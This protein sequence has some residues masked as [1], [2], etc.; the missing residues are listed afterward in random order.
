ME[1][2]T[3]FIAILFLIT[4]IF[5]LQIGEWKGRSLERY[6]YVMARE[7]RDFWYAAYCALSEDTGYAIDPLTGRKVKNEDS[8]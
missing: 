4:L 7:D 3:P 5:G 2:W 1:S 6:R 8:H